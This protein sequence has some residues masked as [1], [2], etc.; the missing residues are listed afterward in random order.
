MA[1]HALPDPQVPAGTAS[2]QPPPL[3][4]HRDAR[5][6]AGPPRPRP[7]ITQDIAFFFEGARRA[8][9]L[10]QRCTRLR[11]AAPPAPP[12]LRR[13]RSFE[14]DTVEASG[15][16]RVYS[17]VVIHHPQVPAF[18]YPLPI[19]LIELEEGTRLVADLDGIDPADIA[20]R[21]AGRPRFVAFDDELSLPVF[22]PT[23]R[24]T[25]LMDFTF[26]EEQ[27]AVGQAA[28]GIFAGIVD[29]GPGGRGRGDRRPGRRASCGPPWPRPTCS[30]WPSPRSTGGAGL[31]L[32]ELCLVLEAAGPGGGP[33]ARCGPPSSS[34]RCPW[35]AS[36]PGPARAGGCP[37]WWPATSV[38][39][40]AADRAAAAR[41]DRPAPVDGRAPTVA[42]L[43][44][45]RARTWPCPRPTW[46]PGCSCRR[47]TADGD[48]A[49]GPRRPRR[50]G[51]APGTG[52]SPPTGRSTPTST[53]TAPPVARRRAGAAPAEG[54]GRC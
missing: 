12:G 24:R 25:A 52:R 17:F 41:R 39:T 22:R 11:H 35:P 19:G 1:D 4:R 31:G 54:R 40:A 26:T 51:V 50:P 14:W 37:A 29:P 9:L 20:D 43:A 34:A 48:G 16:G 36:A 2:A 47:R 13:C 46:P 44:A 15:R 30:G 38:S 6:P 28:D 33:R 23:D 21:H 10:I 32:T 7:A 49:R 8:Q 3:D 53:S 18:D 27:V 42:R 45:D 5:A